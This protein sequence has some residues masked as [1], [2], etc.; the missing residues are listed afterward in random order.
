V[1]ATDG[2]TDIATQPQPQ[3]GQLIACGGNTLE[4]G[5]G[6]EKQHAGNSTYYSHQADKTDIED[7]RSQCPPAES[8]PFHV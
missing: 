7:C 8:C 1:L 2:N 5:K 6:Q 3:H 4:S